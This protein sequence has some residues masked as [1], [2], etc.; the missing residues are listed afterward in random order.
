MNAA[1]AIVGKIR[2]SSEML[3]FAGID[4]RPTSVRASHVLPVT[5]IRGI[6]NVEINSVCKLIS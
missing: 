6:G 4:R 5:S 1:L 2:R 3:L